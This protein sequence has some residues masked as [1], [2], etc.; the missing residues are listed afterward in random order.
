M[1]SANAIDQNYSSV[2]V[3]GVLV[4]A[5]TERRTGDSEFGGGNSRGGGRRQTRRTW[6]ASQRSQ[7]GKH[8]VFFCYQ[9]HGCNLGCC[10][11]P[12]R[13][14]PIRHPE[15][16]GSSRRRTELPGMAGGNPVRVSGRHHWPRSRKE[17]VLV[18]WHRSEEHTSEL[19]SRQYLVCRL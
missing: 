17:D 5:R 3:A 12:H 13:L 9:F 10:R 18:L 19:Q 6:L 16:A 14:Y 7:A 8:R 1:F 4:L 2:V 15:N 11:R